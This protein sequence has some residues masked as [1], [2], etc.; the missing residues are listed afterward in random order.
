MNIK[1]EEVNSFEPR[2]N[3]RLPLRKGHWSS[4][5]DKMLL[6][7]SNHRKAEI[8]FCQRRL[9]MHFDKN[10]SQNYPM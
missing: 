3:R 5:R 8:Y 7:V 10:T 9:D 6:E 2:E 1:R 4:V